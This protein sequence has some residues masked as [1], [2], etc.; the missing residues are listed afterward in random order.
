MGIPEIYEW[1]LK[2][3][4]ECQ[5]Q[6]TAIEANETELET[7]SEEVIAKFYELVLATE[8]NFTN[9]ISEIEASEEMVDTGSNAESA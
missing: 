5:N 3:Q 2:M 7:G 9:L 6:I 8:T 1:L 4:L